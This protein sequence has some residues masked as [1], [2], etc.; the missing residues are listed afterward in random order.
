MRR[1]IFAAA[2]LG[3]LAL[4]ASAQPTADMAY[5]DAVRRTMSDVSEWVDTARAGQVVQV[6]IGE[7]FALE[8]PVERNAVEFWEPTSMPAFVAP[9]GGVRPPDA[10]TLSAQ[11]ARLRGMSQTRLEWWIFEARQPGRADIRMERQLSVGSPP[12]SFTITVVAQ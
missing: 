9:I 12:Q 2:G 3:L 11:D 1:W 7:H 10:E 5:R 8:L 4:S 6:R